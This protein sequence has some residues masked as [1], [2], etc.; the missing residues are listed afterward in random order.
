MSR[1]T[2]AEE[3]AELANPAPTKGR[4][5]NLEISVGLYFDTNH[6]AQFASMHLIFFSIYIFA[7][8]D[9]EADIFG[10]GPALEASDDELLPL[11]KPKYAFA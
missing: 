5:A 7:E 8:F 2:L 10:S 3:L 6:L 1:K 11:S 4:Y 9:P